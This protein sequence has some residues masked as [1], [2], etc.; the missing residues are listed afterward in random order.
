MFSCGIP[1]E[2]THHAEYI[3]DTMLDMIEAVKEVSETLIP[4][5]LTE[6]KIGNSFS[7]LYFSY[8]V[9]PTTTAY[10]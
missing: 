6:I 8:R 2:T 4:G 1:Y 5:K 3:A 9:L 10:L 7:L